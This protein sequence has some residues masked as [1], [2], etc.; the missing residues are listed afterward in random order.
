MQAAMFTFFGVIITAGVNY[1]ISR[2]KHK[3]DANQQVLNSVFMQMGIMTNR[4]EFLEK[5]REDLIADIKNLMDELNMVKQENAKLMAEN[6]ILREQLDLLREE[7]EE[8][9]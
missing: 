2:K 5:D 7:L 3:L 4:L 8:R 1:F 9:K 6:K